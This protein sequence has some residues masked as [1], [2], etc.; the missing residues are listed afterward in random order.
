MLPIKINADE[1]VNTTEKLA[2]NIVRNIMGYAILALFAA[3]VIL[4]V[5]IVNLN[6]YIRQTLETNTRTMNSLTAK[7]IQILQD[8]QY[9]FITS[10]ETERINARRRGEEAAENYIKLLEAEAEPEPTKKK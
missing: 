7:N 2:G 4:G 3:I 5:C 1:I 6:T 8:I 10:K 9:V